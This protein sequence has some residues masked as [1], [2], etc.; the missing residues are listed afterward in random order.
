VVLETMMKLV[1]FIYI[2]NLSLFE[3]KVSLY[4]LYF[5]CLITLNSVNC[6]MTILQLVFDHK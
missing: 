5:V 2:F 6:K 3:T 1:F 4:F